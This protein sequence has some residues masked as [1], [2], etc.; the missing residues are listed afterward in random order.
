MTTVCAGAT[1][2]KVFRNHTVVF[3][4]ENGTAPFQLYI[5]FPLLVVLRAVRIHIPHL[6]IEGA[7]VWL[8]RKDFQGRLQWSLDCVCECV[9]CL[10]G[11]ACRTC[12]LAWPTGASCLLLGAKGLFPNSC[13]RTVSFVAGNYQFNRLVSGWSQSLA[14]TARTSSQARLSAVLVSKL[15]TVGLLMPLGSVLGEP[16]GGCW[17]IPRPV[18]AAPGGLCVLRMGFSQERVF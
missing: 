8:S 5:W 15:G 18:L 14:P 4:L 12:A 3:H 1:L 6:R 10:H 16:W 2:G 7:D 11:Q 13:Q 17:N 9:V